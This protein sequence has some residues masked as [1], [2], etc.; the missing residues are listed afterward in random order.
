MTI[1]TKAREYMKDITEHIKDHLSPPLMRYHYEIML[2]SPTADPYSLMDSRLEKIA[3]ESSA[4]EPIEWLLS[5]DPHGKR[6]LAESRR[7][8]QLPDSTLAINERIYAGYDLMQ[9]FSR[10]STTVTFITRKRPDQMTRLLDNIFKGRDVGYR[11]V[12]QHRMD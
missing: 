9:D 10:Y 8:F 1:A 7:E 11:L 2:E 4:R 3:L 6:P 5:G 12:V